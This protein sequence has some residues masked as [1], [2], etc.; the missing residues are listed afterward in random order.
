MFQDIPYLHSLVSTVFCAPVMWAGAL[1]D[2]VVEDEVEFF[3]REAV[4]LGENAVN[5]VDNLLRSLVHPVRFIRL[6]A[7]VA[8]ADVH[9]AVLRFDDD[10]KYGFPDPKRR[11]TTRSS[12]S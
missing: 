7:G 1:L 11:I 8:P 12:S 10:R 5:F 4:A 6:F 3:V 9:E 2:V